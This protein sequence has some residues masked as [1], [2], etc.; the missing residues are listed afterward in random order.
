MLPSSLPAVGPK[1]FSPIFL[2]RRCRRR[3]S[4]IRPDYGRCRKSLWNNQP[5]QRVGGGAVFELTRTHDGWK[6]Q[7]LHSFAD[8]TNDGGGPTAGLVFDSAGNLDGTTAFGG[9][10]NCYGSGCGTVF[11][12]ALNWY[13]AGAK[14]FYLVSQE[15]TA[16]AGIRIAIL[17]S[18]GRETCTEQQAAAQPLGFAGVYSGE[19]YG[20]VP[21]SRLNVT[22]NKP[23]IPGKTKGPD[24][25]T[26]D[27][28]TPGRW[29]KQPNRSFNAPPQMARRNIHLHPVCREVELVRSS[30][31]VLR[32]SRK[33]VL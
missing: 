10:S 22:P 20:G 19:Q 1:R 29:A 9:G 23:I 28:V 18:I 24:V 31:D 3:I 5:G 4:R 33:Q 27:P 16:T 26:L 15:Q 32:V 14:A 8:G 12:L 7:V 17:S 6:H 11:K 21:F 2:R 30:G 25:I 13:A